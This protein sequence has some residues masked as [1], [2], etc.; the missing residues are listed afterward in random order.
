MHNRCTL[1]L[2]IRNSVVLYVINIRRYNTIVVFRLRHMTQR[3]TTLPTYHVL[4]EEAKRTQPGLTVFTRSVISSH[5]ITNPIKATF[6]STGGVIT[7]PDQYRTL[8]CG[9]EEQM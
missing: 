6:G 4:H 8:A 5:L 7:F 2:E 3:A 9:A 1:L